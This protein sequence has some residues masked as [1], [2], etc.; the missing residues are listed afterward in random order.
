MEMPREIRIVGQ[1]KPQK[2]VSI[3]PNFS[4]KRRTAM[5]MREIPMNMALV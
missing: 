2:L 3:T 1:R 5:M 4:R